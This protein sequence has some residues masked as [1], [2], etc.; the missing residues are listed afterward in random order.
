MNMPAH[1][2]VIRATVAS[3]GRLLSAD[4]PLLSLQ[5]E[6]GGGIG[7]AL[8][9][10]QLAEMARL[11]THL[12]IALSRPVVVAAERPRCPRRSAFSYST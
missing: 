10:P 7:S 2:A 1:P 6:A 12:G 4:A 5:Q 9:I 3:D 8:A 11:A